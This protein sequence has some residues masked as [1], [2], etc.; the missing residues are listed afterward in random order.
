MWLSCL[1]LW[2]KS[3]WVEHAY[4]TMAWYLLVPFDSLS[5]FV[6]TPGHCFVDYIKS[7]SLLT[8][9]ELFKSCCLNTSKT[10]NVSHNCTYE[11]NIE[12]RK[13]SLIIIVH[14]VPDYVYAF[15]FLRFSLKINH[16]LNLER[17]LSD[18]QN[19]HRL[20]SESQF[21]PVTC[22]TLIHANSQLQLKT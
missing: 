12:I 3:F 18:P 2:A 9:L 7:T 4:D 17:E 21:Y 10:V 6:G 15:F 20:Q 8:S 19:A 5:T 14:N 11:Y 16:V 22:Y 13:Q 1:V